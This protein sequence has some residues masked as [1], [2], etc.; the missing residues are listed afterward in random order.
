[1]WK[2]ILSSCFVL[3]RNQSNCVL[4]NFCA[5]LPLPDGR[6]NLSAVVSGYIN[7]GFAIYRIESGAVGLS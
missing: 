3:E 2:V 5:G 4:L 7:S 1:M 6:V